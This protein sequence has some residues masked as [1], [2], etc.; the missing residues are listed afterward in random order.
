MISDQMRTEQ[1]EECNIC[2]AADLE[3]VD[4]DCAIARCRVCGYVFNNPRPAYEELVKFYSRP[5]QY[6]S[7]LKE[8]PERQRTWTHRLRRLS[9]TR[10]PGSLLD[11]GT[12]IGQ[13][14]DVA[15]GSFTEIY[16]TE[17]S[18]VAIRIADERYGL[19]LFQGTIDDIE[20]GDLKFDNLSLFHVLEHVTDPPSTI[21][22][23]HS[24]LVDNGVL[25]IA[26]PN[27]VFSLRAILRRKLTEAGLMN[28]SRLGKFGLPRISLSA[29]SA[30]VHL[31]H[32]TPKVLDRLLQAAGFTVAVR[33]LDPYFISTG[34]PRLKATAYYY[35]CLGLKYVTGINFYD[36]M[37]VIARK[38]PLI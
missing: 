31:S 9:S 20:W 32:F 22:K 38:K 3:I 8:L 23:C 1:L 25:V 10:K 37:L 19:K 4:A 17:V 29:E 2:G 34:I 16:G 6:D 14:L 27:E 36:T 26:V 11:V 12:G 21:A 5:S 28:S 24:L 35:F 18:P 13:F 30:E 7:W 33:T 15:R